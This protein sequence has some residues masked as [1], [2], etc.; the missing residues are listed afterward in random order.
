MADR[1]SYGRRLC[2][3][4]GD[5]NFEAVQYIGMLDHDMVKYD[6]KEE[7]LCFMMSIWQC[8]MPELEKIIC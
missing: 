1:L 4:C 2:S 7:K 5:T 6:G 3:M 8:V